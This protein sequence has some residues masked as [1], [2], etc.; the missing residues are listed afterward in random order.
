MS[1]PSIKVEFDE[2]SDK[3]QSNESD[4]TSSPRDSPSQTQQQ[5]NQQQQQQQQ[6]AAAQ[7]AAQ[8]LG[9]QQI[10]TLANIQNLQNLIPL[11]Q[12]APQ[13]D[14]KPQ[15]SSPQLLQVQGI[16]GQFIQQGNQLIQ[17]GGGNF[18]TIQPMQTVTVDGQEALFIPSAP[19]QNQHQTLQVLAGQ[20][21]ITPNGQIIRGPS[22][23]VPQYNTIQLPFSNAGNV[24]VRP[25]NIPQVVQLPQLQQTVPVQVPI[26]ANGQTVFHTV[27][28]PIQALGP[29]ILQAQAANQIQMIPQ[30]SQ[31]PQV[32]Q[33]GQGTTLAQILTPNGQIQTIQ[34]PTQQAN[35]QQ[36]IQIVQAPSQITSN[37]TSIAWNGNTVTCTPTM[38]DNQTSQPQSI[39][40]PQQALSQPISVQGNPGLTVIPASSLSNFLQG[41]NL[42]NNVRAANTPQIQVQQIP[43]INT[44]SSPIQTVHIPGLGNVQLIPAS[45]L[46]LGG[47]SPVVSSTQQPP[48]A[49]VVTPSQ[50]PPLIP[51]PQGIQLI[52]AQ[53]QQVQQ[54]Q[55]DPNDPTRFQ[56]LNLCSPGGGGVTTSI[57]M[58]NQEEDSLE[59]KP[60]S[61]RVACTCPNC[62]EGGER[63]AD[64]KKVHICHIEG[65]NKVYGKTSH[66]R[67]HLRWHT[68]ER[69]FVCTWQFCGKRF[70]RSDE[71]QR[72]NRTHTGEKRFQCSE[73][74]KKFMRSDHLQKHIKTHSKTRCTS[75]TVV[76]EDSKLEL[77]GGSTGAGTPESWI[78]TD[79][80]RCFLVNIEAPGTNGGAESPGLRPL[81][82]DDGGSSSSG[83]EK[84]MI[85]LGG[86]TGEGSELTIVTDGTDC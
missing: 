80:N 81:S 68:G 59:E 85:T 33:V 44:Q 23:V 17:V 46:N 61:R 27:H 24:S 35:N 65:C 37:A 72:H 50:P 48:A 66:L 62:T 21:L 45:A 20:T 8:A 54:L 41:N 26:T 31:I 49:P 47:A 9:Q 22:S 7:Q 77:S 25:A 58:V 39:V 11:Q 2:T 15:F 10:I 32:T 52:S 67:A 34:I 79:G 53:G 76:T 19:P 40:I 84:M 56:I 43:Q 38:Q 86:E 29:N 75:L 64:R 51:L 82:P 13:Q 74:H 70:T 3:G 6:Q 4:N 69:P 55:Q 63:T 36:T 5:Q 71:L 28:F 83:D 57:E 42:N 18:N 12:Q 1:S 78:N 60:R 73:C 16:P 30:L 14:V